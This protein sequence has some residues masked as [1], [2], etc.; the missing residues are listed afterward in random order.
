MVEK[1]TYDGVPSVEDILRLNTQ[2]GEKYT[3][4][5]VAAV[6]RKEQ[7]P[8][9]NAIF[10]KDQPYEDGINPAI[11]LERNALPGVSTE[12]RNQLRSTAAEIAPQFIKDGY[13]YAFRG[14][15]PNL[16]KKGL[17]SYRFQEINLSLDQMLRELQSEPLK[18]H[19]NFSPSNKLE[20][21]M[22]IHSHGGRGN[23]LSTTT[24]YSIAKKHPGYKENAGTVYVLKI[25]AS[26]AFKNYAS[27]VS[28]DEQ[29]ILAV[30]Y[31]LPDSIIETVN[32][33]EHERLDIRGF[34]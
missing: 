20:E 11:I 28:G 1:I 23:F 2:F 24:D 30:D 6:E 32:P 5:K 31:I 7:D 12:F 18:A 10:S 25:P 13:V 26:Q 9:L 17:Y 21:F 4:L 8:Q 16:A 29:E 15:Y 33:H 22:W 27:V 34:M 3:K 19:W 14:D